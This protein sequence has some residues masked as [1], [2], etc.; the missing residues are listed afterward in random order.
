MNIWPFSTIKNQR[1]EI[2]RL[3]DQLADAMVGDINIKE[4]I[5]NEKELGMQ[6]EGSI[7]H[8]FAAGF[9]H[10]FHAQ[11]ATNFLE[12]EFS[13][14]EQKAERYTL[15]IQKLSGMRPA[16]KANL[17]KEAII[18]LMNAKNQDEADAAMQKLQE[19]TAN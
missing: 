5:A 8:V 4:M 15:T 19:L 17:T 18:E 16:I 14:P 10:H 1:L 7:L 11:G 3:Q 13:D 2:E 6:L 12:V 9:I